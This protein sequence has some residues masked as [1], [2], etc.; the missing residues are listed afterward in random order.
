MRKPV[1]LLLAVVLAIGVLFT[2]I[3]QSFSTNGQISSQRDGL[4]NFSPP[5]TI[6]K[7]DK[8]AGQSADSRLTKPEG[9]DLT[10]FSEDAPGARDLQF[11]PD[12]TLLV[13]LRTQGKVIALPDQNNDGHADQAIEVLKGL[14]NPHGLAFWQGKLFVAEEKQVSRYSWDEQNKTATLERK[15]F[16]TPDGIRLPGGGGGHQTRSLTFD[17]QGNLYISIGS[18]C[19]VCE[20]KEPWH[21][22]VVITDQDGN[23]PRVFSKGLRNAVFLATHPQTGKI[24]VT[25]M[26]RDQLGDNIPGEEINILQENMHYGWPYCY[27]QRIYDSQFGRQTP[28]FCQSTVPPI[29][30][31]QA[32][33]APLGLAFVESDQ[34]PADWQGDLLVAFHGSWNRSVPT[35]YKVVKLDVE[36][37]T[38][39][40]QTDV[41]A[42]FLQGRQSFGRPVDVTFD[43]AGHL[44][45]SDDKAGTVYLLRK[46]SL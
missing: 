17:P 18:T 2:L 43:A 25:E 40:G 16:D 15:L 38:I 33:S 24:W 27:G 9:Y 35:G 8:N 4:L 3:Y 13:S 26:G 34:F 45:I 23:N 7:T 11:T 39:T 28:E 37:E 19:N 31:M 41:V 46:S 12:G 36:G 42:G 5:Q 44:Y 30:E 21:A 1:L 22:A 29:F 14:Q 10:I 20:Q 6:E 32:H